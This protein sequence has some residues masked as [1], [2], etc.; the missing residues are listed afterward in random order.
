MAPPLSRN[1]CAML[2]VSILSRPTDRLTHPHTQTKSV[3]GFSDNRMS[4]SHPSVVSMLQCTELPCS[5]AADRTCA[6]QPRTAIL[7]SS[8]SAV[9]SLQGLSRLHA[10]Y[11]GRRSPCNCRCQSVRAHGYRPP[12]EGHRYRHVQVHGHK[13]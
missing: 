9:V 4:V 11:Q 10:C 3:D 13:T 5:H 6:V 8:D 2:P 7:V 12:V 1:H